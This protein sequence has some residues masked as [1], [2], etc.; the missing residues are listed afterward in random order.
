MLSGRRY[1]NLTATHAPVLFIDVPNLTFTMVIQGDNLR[2]QHGRGK[3]SVA[4]SQIWKRAEVICSMISP[5]A[6][7]AR[8]L[9]PA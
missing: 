1:L 4:V 5:S 9:L 3:L 7:D 6:S 8:L 2:W